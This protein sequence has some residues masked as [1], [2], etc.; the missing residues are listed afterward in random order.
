[1]TLP[2][3]CISGLSKNVFKVYSRSFTALTQ[4]GGRQVE[5]TLLAE[6]YDGKVTFDFMQSQN[7]FH[8]LLALKHFYA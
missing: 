7:N 3:S 6:H 5:K 1:M 8:I 2:T 4:Q